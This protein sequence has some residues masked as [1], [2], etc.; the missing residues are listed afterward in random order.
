M[1]L[2]A[3]GVFFAAGP[4][5]ADAN[6]PRALVVVAG[7]LLLA[8]VLMI[9]GQ[10]Y[11]KRTRWAFGTLWAGLLL[12]LSLAFLQ[13]QQDVDARH[14]LEAMMDGK[15]ETIVS[16]EVRTPSESIVCTSRSALDY[17]QGCIADGS[18]DP[19][20]MQGGC[21]CG[22]R[23]EFADGLIYD[24]RV[25]WSEEGFS[26]KNDEG[27]PMEFIPFHT[28]VPDQLRSLP[29]F[30]ESV[31]WGDTLRVEEPRGHLSKQRQTTS[32]R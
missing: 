22:V 28:P 16:F 26:T 6:G 31:A 25:C 27:W 11:G 24:R 12:T 19:E 1:F 15:S 9:T 32:I 13:L 30:P 4:V 17:L 3:F 18:L 20:R 10:P 23:I 5:L 21:S 14:R 8:F 7:G 29:T 2:V